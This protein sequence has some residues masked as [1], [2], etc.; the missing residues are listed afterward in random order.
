MRSSWAP[1]RRRIFWT[2]CFRSVRRSSTALKQPRSIRCALTPLSS[3]MRS[4]NA[5]NFSRATDARFHDR[6]RENP[7]AQHRVADHQYQH[8]ILAPAGEGRIAENLAGC[9]M[10][11][12]DRDHVSGHDGD[13]RQVPDEASID[14]P[15]ID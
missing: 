10:R 1:I 14:D 11:E 5:R 6:L 9:D 12:P 13:D 3:R 7:Q 8:R 15:D 4:K 2:M